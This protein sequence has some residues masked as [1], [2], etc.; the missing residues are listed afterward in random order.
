MSCVQH[1]KRSGPI[2]SSVLIRMASHLPC[3]LRTDRNLP[4]GNS[5]RSSSGTG[6]GS[7]CF[8][9]E[10]FSNL[11]PDFAQ[12]RLIVDQ[13]QLAGEA[14][15]HTCSPITS[16]CYWFKPFVKTIRQTPQISKGEIARATLQA[17]IGGQDRLAI[18]QGRRCLSSRSIPLLIASVFFGTF[19]SRKLAIVLGGDISVES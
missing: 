17:E 8:P 18:S 10:G 5:P 11:H 2:Y 12:Q 14:C 16:T 3:P 1:L 9:G 19:S 13:A 15:S 7:K 4:T 6:R